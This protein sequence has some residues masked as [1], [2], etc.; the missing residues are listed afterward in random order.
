ME[1]SV[2]SQPV[3]RSCWHGSSAETTLRILAALHALRLTNDRH[4]HLGDA[5]GFAAGDLV[6][7]AELLGVEGLFGF[8]VDPQ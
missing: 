6:H 3:L 7:Q 5:D 2:A 8:H 1:G 4:A